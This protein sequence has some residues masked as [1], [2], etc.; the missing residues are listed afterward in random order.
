[1]SR[2]VNS[3]IP[4]SCTMSDS[5][6]RAAEGIVSPE[7]SP[8]VSEEEVSGGEDSA[9][10]A[11]DE[12]DSGAVKLDVCASGDDEVVCSDDTGTLGADCWND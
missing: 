2:N 10:G 1:M 8:A 4:N 9:A 6:G 7:T 12:D 3:P 11:L 5:G